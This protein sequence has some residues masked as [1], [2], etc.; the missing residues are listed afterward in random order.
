MRE[1]KSYRT[2]ICITNESKIYFWIPVPICFLCDG[3]CIGGNPWPQVCALLGDWSS[4]GAALHFSFVVDN[5]AGIVLEVERH[6]V[7]PMKRL[8]LSDNHGRYH[9]NW[10][11]VSL[12]SSVIIG[13]AYQVQVNSWWNVSNSTFFLNSGFPFFTEAITMSPTAAAGIRFNRLPNPVTE[14]TYRF[15][16][17]ERVESRE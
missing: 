13:I 6:T 14:M 8:P 16:A 2:W 11:V 10:E 12:I 5:N 3:R 7:L 9:L 1:T 15:L 4:Y 17:P